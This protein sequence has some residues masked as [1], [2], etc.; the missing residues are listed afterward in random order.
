MK[1]IDPAQIRHVHL[2]AICGAGMGSL[3]GMLKAKGLHVTGSD[4]NVYPPMSDQL[5]ALGIPIMQGYLPEHLEPRPDLIVIGNVISKGN[6]EGDAAIASGVPYVSM[7]EALRLFFF[8][9]RTTVAVCGTHGKTTTT[10]LASWIATTARLDPTYLVGGVLV[11]T[12]ASY[13]VGQGR[14]AIVEGDE[15]DTAWFD[16]IAKFVRYRP[17]IAILG[18]VEFD[19]ADIYPDFAAVRH[20]FSLLVE[21]L[22]PEG[23]LIAGIDCPTVNELCAGA[24]CRVVT[25]AVDRPADWTGKIESMY[26]DRMTSR[27]FARGTEYGLFETQIVGGY[28]LKNILATLVLADHLG[29][30]LADVQQG[31]ATFAG[32]KRRQQVRGEAAGVLVI[33]DFGHH[34]TAVRVTLESLRVARPGRR[35]IEV[36]EPPSKT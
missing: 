5:D 34:P 7:P 13:H 9:E 15:Y 30:P 21:S 20:A 4:Q 36:F 29:L 23:L 1:N 22:P 27:V 26:S 2:V 6:P 3:A 24:K 11:N 14:L 10:A 25:Y 16:K 17:D 32:V 18:N 35:V 33:D 8:N 31:L 28:N 19:H 12:D